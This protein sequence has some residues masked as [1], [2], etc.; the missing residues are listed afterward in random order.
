MGRRFSLL[1]VAVILVQLACIAPFLGKD[2]V[3]D[4]VLPEAVCSP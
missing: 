2:I 3:P 4:D 1:I